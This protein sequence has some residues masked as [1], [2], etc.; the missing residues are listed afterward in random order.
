MQAGAILKQAVTSLVSAAA[1]QNGR[2]ENVNRHNR[3]TV[4]VLL[5]GLALSSLGT[6]SFA[7]DNAYES[8]TYASDV[9]SYGMLP[10]YGR[11]IEDGSYPVI[12]RT[13]ST[14]FKLHEPVLTVSGGELQVTFYINSTSYDKV[15]MGTKKEASSSDRE[16]WIPAEVRDD[17]SWF[18]I[19]VDALDQ[20]VYCAA[21]SK[22]RKRWYGRQL[23]FLASSLPE[24]ALHITLPD[25]ELIE[26]AL[27]AYQSS[28]SAAGETDEAAEVSLDT[29]EEN[30]SNAGS[31][32]AEGR[33][34]TAYESVFDDPSAVSVGGEDGE[35]S[36]E[37]AM[38][39]G[40]GRASVSSPT[41]L[42]VSEGRAYATLLWS[43]THYDY[44]I[45]NGKRYDNEA[46]D[47]GIS[48]FTIP[49]TQMDEPID[50][51]ADTTA[52]GDP[53]E[54]AYSLTF[55]EE[56]IGDKGLIPQEAAKRVLIAAL[57]MIAVG[58]ILNYVVKRKRR[59]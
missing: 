40:S 28:A 34:L 43:S 22:A 15:F 49:I 16:Q 14:Y 46:E 58:G 35:Y 31:E 13:N 1:R 30:E 21:Y 42:T 29:I 8:S 7:A 23:L 12:S 56:S 33:N 51:I 45:L 38:T 47:G 24:E 55:Y 17:V 44:M 25:Y 6:G 5:F 57:I 36:I 20:P 10:V 11:D 32:A 19:P 3:I 41:Y 53:V 59:R 9:T 4:F 48:R 39:G 37:V 54:I 26:K 27:S 18:T 52:M 50:I 2:T